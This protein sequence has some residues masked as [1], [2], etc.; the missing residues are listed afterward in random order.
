MLPEACASLKPCP[1]PTTPRYALHM[2][3]IRYSHLKSTVEFLQHVR[4]DK[5][6]S[7]VSKNEFR[8][9]PAGKTRSLNSLFSNSDILEESKG[10][11][12]SFV[13][14]NP[15]QPY[16]KVTEAGSRS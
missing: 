9:L 5:A 12:Y 15:L 10:F 1:T 14:S 13:Q 11:W 8:S 2:D 3:A 16:S 4:M 6:L 7:D